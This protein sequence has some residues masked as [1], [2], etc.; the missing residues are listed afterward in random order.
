MKPT[1]ELL[2]DALERQRA[3]DPKTSFIVQAPAGSGKTELLVRRYLTLLARVPYP[4]AIIAITFTRKAANEMRLRIMTALTFAH[5]ENITTVQDKDKER[6]FLAQKALLQNKAFGWNLLSH[7]NRLRILTID[8]FC[9]S[10]T[11]QM[12]LQ[13]GLSEQWTPTDNPEWLYR[14]A[15]HEFLNPLDDKVTWFSAL[16]QLLSHLD[17]DFQRLEN[18]LVPL[19]A[20]REQWLDYLLLQ[21]PDD[22]RKTLEQSLWDLSQNNVKQLNQLINPH[23]AQ[24]L[25]KL[26][27]F[28]LQQRQRSSLKRHDDLTF[29]NAASHLVLTAQD[30]FRKRLGKAEGFTIDATSKNKILKTEINRLKSQLLDLIHDLSQQP[31][32]K[33]MFIALKH[34][35]PSHYTETQWHILKSLFELLPV[36]VAHLKIVFQQQK[37]VDHT[38]VLLAACSALGHPENPTDLALALD[39]QIQHLLVDEFQDTST[40]QLRLIEKLI[41]GWEKQDGR[42]LFLV[43]D[44]MQ[45]IYRFRKAEV[46]LFLEVRQRGIG[47]LPLQP[48]TLRVNFRSTSGIVDW[49]NH[50]FSQLLPDNPNRSIDAIGYSPSDAYT[51]SSQAEKSVFTYWQLAEDSVLGEITEAEQIVTTIQK[52][53]REDP[54]GSIALLV[55]SRSHLHPILPRLRQAKIPYQ[56]LEIDSLAE[57]PAL[58]DLLSLTRALH[59]FGDSISWLALL[60][61]PYCGLSLRDLYQIM[62][63][64]DK[65]KKI[66]IWEQLKEFEKIPLNLETKQRLRRIVSVLK[67]S[68]QQQGRVSFPQW[69]KQTWLHL[70]GPTTLSHWEEMEDI[71]TYFN[72]LATKL[73]T[74]G[75][76]F[77]FLRIH[78]EL[79]T[80]YTQSTSHDTHSVEIMTL[81]KAKGLEFDHVILPGLHRSNRPEPYPLLLY[82]EQRSVLHQKNFLLAPI[83]ID[84]QE[85]DFI[86]NYL[87]AEE[88]KKNQAERIRLLYV[89]CTRTKKSLHLFGTFTQDSAGKLQSPDKQSLLHHLWPILSI[90][91]E[92]LL[93][94]SPSKVNQKNSTTQTVLKRLPATW[95][96]P[97][98]PIKSFEIP[99]TMPSQ[100]VVYHWHSH[101]ERIF[102]TVIHRLLYQISQ[103]GLEHWI[104]K[105]NQ[106]QTLLAG[107]LAH[108]GLLDSEIPNVLITLKRCLEKVIACSRARWIL[109]QQHWMAESEYAIT[110]IL[111]GKCE[112]FIIDRTFIDPATCSRWIIDYKTTNYQGNQ[113]D[114]FLKEAK[115]RHQEQLNGYARAFLHDKPKKIC[116]GLYFPLTSLWCAWEFNASPLKTIVKKISHAH[117]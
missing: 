43:G 75:D 63:W 97:V 35:P 105:I 1:F 98:S 59:H 86:Y 41:T 50:S 22:L 29:W 77:D 64:N 99:T 88:Q 18:L 14:L 79:Q 45:S 68:L 31:G 110:V 28:S 40:L 27:N 7:P 12:P 60:R 108:Y 19:L 61:S 36:L 47:S 38:E 93:S 33:E 2:A 102:G 67:Y 82:S 87:L 49:V 15:I 96:S 65:N 3:L 42:T 84:P 46:C 57:K 54:S 20:R 103:D 95:Q 90:K 52:I 117:K 39:Y 116:C 69:V 106:S 11:R 23:D 48:L 62:Q 80:L 107:L 91:S 25:L 74:E 113:P 58:Q 78:E 66:T 104:K 112:N 76:S 72:F 26:L 92:H 100:P 81:H 37:K 4:E 56:A 8:S 5:E 109:S 94:V 101:T 24:K 89:A 16:N 85:P 83:P 17:N 44:P 115:Q 21:P 34:T 70:G 32:V 51:R 10:L 30:T 55:R 6:H 9:Q 73:K 13:A 71:E 114:L 111:H 53:K